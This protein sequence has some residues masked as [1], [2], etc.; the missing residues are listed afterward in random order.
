M[1]R[2]FRTADSILSGSAWAS[3][4]HARE[5]SLSAAFWYLHL[6]EWSHLRSWTAVTNHIQARK[7][8]TKWQTPCKIKVEHCKLKPMPAA[9]WSI[10]DT[11]A[12]QSI[13]KV[14]HTSDNLICVDCSFLFKQSSTETFENLVHSQL[15]KFYMPMQ[16]QAIPMKHSNIKHLSNDI[17][18][19][20]WYKKRINP[21][22]R[23]RAY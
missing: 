15:Y 10:A 13:W 2:R 21:W 8:V 1:K 11:L 16:G 12:Y 4:K 18:S 23:I 22:P 19:R 20:L 7:Q 5:G 6:S 17:L 9:S 14:H 3:S